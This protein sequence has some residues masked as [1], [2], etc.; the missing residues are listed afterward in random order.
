DRPTRRMSTPEHFSLS[1][2]SG[3]TEPVLADPST[4][5][6]PVTPAPLRDTGA[7]TIPLRP[8]PRWRQGPTSHAGGRLRCVLACGGEVTSVCEGSESVE[9]DCTLPI[10]H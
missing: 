10:G 8:L 1:T 9:L 6:M 2:H 4:R 5:L 3:R 7:A